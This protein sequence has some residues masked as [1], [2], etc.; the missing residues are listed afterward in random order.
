M[1]RREHSKKKP[2][3][4]EECCMLWTVP[5]LCVRFKWASWISFTSFFFFL[6][7]IEK[8]KN[9]ALYAFHQHEKVSFR[10]PKEEEFLLK[11]FFWDP[12]KKLCRKF[13]HFV[14]T[15]IRQ[16]KAWAS[17]FFVCLFVMMV[18]F[19]HLNKSEHSSYINTGLSG[20]WNT[21][22][23]ESNKGWPSL[24]ASTS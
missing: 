22:G 14:I 19:L 23:S 4:E 11:I 9:L 7:S 3:C 12:K 20:R 17:F 8:Y 5:G 18:C 15:K 16:L 13:K 10:D 2:L 21:G 6:L 1:S 24:K